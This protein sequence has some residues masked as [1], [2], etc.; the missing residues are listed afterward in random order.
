M[1][2][3]IFVGMTLLFIGLALLGHLSYTETAHKPLLPTQAGDVKVPQQAT[4]YPKN[5]CFLPMC[6][7]HLARVRNHETW[8]VT[9]LLSGS[10]VLLLSL[11]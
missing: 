5:D 11:A 7:F 4:D 2:V 10:I 1:A 3:G 9:F 8:V 6:Y